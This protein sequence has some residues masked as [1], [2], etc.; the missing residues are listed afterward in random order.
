ARASEHVPATVVRE[1]RGTC[2]TKHL[3]LRALLAELGVRSTLMAATQEI[4]LPPG[5]EVDPE[6]A[7]L[8]ADGGV[9]DVHNWLVVHGPRGDV[10]V[11]ATWPLATRA[12]GLPANETFDWERDMRV[13]CTPVETWALTGDEDVADFKA[14]LLAE[15][16][17]PEE[18]ARR[19]A[20]IEAVG[21]AFTR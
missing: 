6:V 18:L 13:A 12:L 5:V 3:L 2:S 14:R 20:F 9:V 11:D 1:W 16:Y 7:R 15:R 8:A 4:A 19:D 10:V 21:R 17:T